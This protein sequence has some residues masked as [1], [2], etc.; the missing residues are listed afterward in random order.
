MA[1]PGP[2]GDHGRRRS[3]RDVSRHGQ[4][5]GRRQGVAS[6]SDEPAQCE[7]M[8]QAVGARAEP[9]GPARSSRGCFGI[10]RELVAG[11]LHVA[12][13]R[14][15]SG[16]ADRAHRDTSSGRFGGWPR[17]DWDGAV[18]SQASDPPRRDLIGSL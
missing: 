8:R 10:T 18:A 2:P 16:T 17:I 4:R 6:R 5:A 1:L 11:D 9:I 13:D 12:R 14:A 15:P 7:V 3:A